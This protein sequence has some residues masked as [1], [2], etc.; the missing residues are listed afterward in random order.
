VKLRAAVGRG[1]R[2]P[3]YTDLYYS[4]PSTKGNPNLKPESA[5]SFEGGVDW[6]ASARLAASL[7][8]FHSIQTNA[9]DYVRANA[10]A[11]WQ[12]ENLTGL[13]FTGVEA[14]VDWRPWTGQQLRLALTTLSGAQ[15]ALGSLQS[16][17]VFNYPVENASAEWV[18]RWK[19]GLLL[20]QR[21]RVVNRL[22]R[23]VYPVWN[24]SAAYER[25]RVKPYVR[26]TNLSNTAYQEIV[27]VPMPGRAFVAGV[28]VALGGRE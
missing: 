22:Q 8:V 12:A 3:T 17:Y 19:N 26:A 4:D 15:N 13:R 10:S 2:I 6:Y 27:G 21:M 18:G 11:L 9:I 7:T 25:W 23:D 24:A 16:E 1:F 5:W 20:R 28:Q 14:A